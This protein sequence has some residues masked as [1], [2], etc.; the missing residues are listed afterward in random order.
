[1][2]MLMEQIKDKKKQKIILVEEGFAD[3]IVITL[4]KIDVINLNCLD[5]QIKVFYRTKEFKDG[6]PV[7]KRQEK[8]S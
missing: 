2:S 5:K 8:L 7:F 1:M 6:F 4:K 3:T